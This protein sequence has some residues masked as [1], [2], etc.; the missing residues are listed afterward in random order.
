MA[1][2]SAERVVLVAGGTGGLG[3]AVSLAFLADGARVVVTCRAPSE[4]AALKTDA[5]TREEMLEGDIVDVTDG[6]AVQR[7]VDAIVERHG[8][9]DAL[10]NTVGGYAGGV[11]LWGNDSGDFY[12]H[13]EIVNLS[14]GYLLAHAVVPECF[15]RGRERS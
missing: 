14:S 2:K 4:L 5:G 7:F 10:V 11:K 8:R 6:P 12:A 15:G 9:L 3:H 13:V 1:A